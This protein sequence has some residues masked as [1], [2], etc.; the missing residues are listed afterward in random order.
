MHFGTIHDIYTTS[1]LKIKNMKTLNIIKKVVLVAMVVVLMS[2]SL[3]GQK[4]YYY[5]TFERGI[6]K[7]NKVAI[8]LI[9]KYKIKFDLN[10]AVK[11]SEMKTA[12]EIMAENELNGLID[13][14]SENSK[15]D[16]NRT[17]SVTD[18]NEE[19]SGL[20]Q[21]T[22]E[23]ME[24]I[25]FDANQTILV[26]EAVGENTELNLLTDELMTDMKFDVNQSISVK[27]EENDL[28]F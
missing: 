5:V 10:N 3:E 12:T 11:F 8:S 18:A 23:L 24:S 22:D 1:T 28:V 13:I 26:T 2:T 14:L 21:L 15:F 20:N 25:K 19:N 4:S 9:E 27:T 7:F 6:T 16:V 17:I